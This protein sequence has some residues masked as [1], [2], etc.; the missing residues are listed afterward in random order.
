MRAIRSYLR[1]IQKKPL[2]PGQ[3]PRCTKQD[4][5]DARRAYWKEVRKA[6]K[7][8]W[9]SFLK[10]VE[11]CTQ[12]GHFNKTII[13]EINS[14]RTLALFKKADGTTMTPDETL[15]SLADAKFPECRDETEQI[16]WKTARQAKEEKATYDLVNDSRADFITMEK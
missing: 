16:P 1:R 13:K 4:L 11:G 2:P 5:T 3:T 14:D 12:M 6:R 7:A 8:G 15:S 10:N 9:N